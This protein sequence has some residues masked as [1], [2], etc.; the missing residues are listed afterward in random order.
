MKTRII[1]VILAFCFIA[2]IAGCASKEPDVV[3]DGELQEVGSGAKSFAL[4]VDDV[5]G[6]VLGYK[7]K[8]DKETVGEALFDLKMIDGEDGPYG[9]YIKSVCGIIADYNDGGK[10]WAFYVNGEYATS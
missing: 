5:A 7:V 10:Y 4:I 9:L 2:S 8:T 3:F 6:N 1:S